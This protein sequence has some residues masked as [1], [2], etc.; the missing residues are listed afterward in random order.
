MPVALVLA[1]IFLLAGSVDASRQMEDLGRAIIAV[2]RGDDVYIGWRLLA[3]DPD[4]IGFNLYRSTAGGPLVRLNEETITQST[5][6]VDD[7]VDPARTNTW[8]VAP[9]IDGTELQLTAQFTLPAGAPVRNYFSIPLQTPNEYTPNDAAV[10]DLDGDGEYDI[11]LKQE[12]KTYDNSQSGICSG[13]TKLEAYKLDGTFLWRIDLGANIR[14]GAHYTP[15]IVFDF[16]GDGISEVAVRT[17]EETVDGLGNRIPDTD[18]DGRTNYVGADGRILEGPEFISIFHGTTGREIAR[19]DYIARGK[20][21]DWGDSYG[22]RCDR[23]L[24]GVAYL[25]GQHPSLII[26]RG[27]YALTKLEA[28]DYRDGRLTRRWRFSSDDWPG[29]AKQGNHNL[30]IGDVD[31]DGFDEI[32]YGA[33]ALDHDGTGLYTTG[34]G[35]GDAMHLSD[36]DPERPGLE[37]FDIHENPKHPYAAEFR[38]A[39]TGEVIWGLPSTD[40]GRGVAMD[41]DPRHL[42]YEC[43]ASGPGLDA[44]YN[45]KGQ[46]ISP[47][48]PSSCNMGVW[49]DGDRLREILNGTTINKWDY[50]NGNE[51]RLLSAHNYDCASN[52]GTK[53]NPC[54]HADILGDWREEVIWRTND[55]Q[56]LR[57]F[58]TTIGTDIRMPT[59]MHDPVYRI[60]AA[61]QNIAYNQ[62]TQTG[63]YMGDLPAPNV[64]L[65]DDRYLWLGNE[66]DP[67][68]A[69]L[70][71]APTVTDDSF[72]FYWRQLQGPSV[73]IDSPDSRE[74][75]L[76]L[77]QIGTYNFQL[78]A[79]GAD[80]QLSDSLKVVV[81]NDPCQAAKAKPQY[82]PITADINNDCIV[83]IKDLAIFAQNFMK[84]MIRQ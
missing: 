83:N 55:N 84:T 64:N 60:S 41:I 25:D 63:F 4:D 74:L 65:G 77:S 17:S 28:W 36:M 16:D 68:T 20:V 35:H 11:V 57:I 61:L 23:F 66:G 67:E 71:V 32:V 22:N 47:N 53:A 1:A 13:T 59:F 30:S 19:D 12:L 70:R 10:G 58:T 43:W 46:V 51:Q 40:V 80:F 48:K 31:D 69:A 29:Y 8:F 3:T 49:W 2:N 21:S 6:F 42:G 56:Q 44:L 26:C 52:N 76:T 33:M 7:S 34:L 79:T 24:M 50:Q 18:D 37:V 38:D 82:T 14:E 73:T 81:A 75:T 39:G 62:P 54:L 27:Y 15:F 9:V 78:T 5:N 72:D 45:C